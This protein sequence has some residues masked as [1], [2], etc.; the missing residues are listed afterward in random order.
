MP[1]QTQEMIKW[2]WGLLIVPIGWVTKII[3]ENH[4]K[5]H[6]IEIALEKQSSHFENLLHEHQK[7]VTNNHPTKEHFDQRMED[8]ITPIQLSVLQNNRD[9]KQQGEKLDAILFKLINKE[10]SK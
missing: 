8:M 5:T 1:E 3:Y 10:G 9:M 6:D 2:L 7:W 4:M